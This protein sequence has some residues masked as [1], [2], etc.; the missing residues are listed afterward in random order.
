MEIDND[1]IPDFLIPQRGHCFHT[2]KSGKTFLVVER[3]FSYTKI[4]YN[5]LNVYYGLQTWFQYHTPA[6]M[7]GEDAS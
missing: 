3:N 7:D 1:L 6:K 4:Y 2:A 5:S